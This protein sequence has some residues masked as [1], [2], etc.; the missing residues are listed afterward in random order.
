MD[1]K[2][3]VVIPVYNAEK[4][5]KDCINSLIN[6]DLYECEFI[7]VDDGST[8]NSNKIIKQYLDIDNRIKLIYQENQGVS[9]ARNNGLSK[10]IGRF[11]SFVDADDYISKNMLSTLYNKA[12]NE[13]LELIMFNYE[14]SANGHKVCSNLCLPI[15][16]KLDKKYIQ[17][18]ILLKFIEGDELNSVCNKFYDNFI[19]TKEKISFPKGLAIGEDTIFNIRY[20]SKINNLMYINYIGYYYR[21]VD[22]SATR[23]IVN[24]DYF[25]YA[26]DI[27]TN[28]V[29][30]LEFINIDP[31]IIQKL[32]I[33]RLIDKVISNVYI[34]LKPNKSMKFKDRYK[35]VKKMI[36]NEYVVNSI[37]T[38]I[39][40]YYNQKGRYERC[41]IKMISK[42]NMIGLYLLTIYSWF[43]NEK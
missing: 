41:I 15:N 37:P 10:S 8:D 42:K 36:T 40:E 9:V 26:L 38:Y 23:N 39:N 13:N 4:Y 18:K 33:K 24:K 11:V 19:I 14:S 5:L 17:N 16:C 12:I 43:R 29:Y 22:T 30:E 27:F 28:N 31:D 2:V 21:E 3:S 25:K 1:V 6:Q 32:K 20:I 34:Y 35:Y 7:F